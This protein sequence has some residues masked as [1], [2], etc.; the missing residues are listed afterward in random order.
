VALCRFSPGQRHWPGASEPEGE[1]DE[2]GSRNQ[3]NSRQLLSGIF[4][5]TYE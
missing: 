2:R 5:I 3:K 1:N 4:S